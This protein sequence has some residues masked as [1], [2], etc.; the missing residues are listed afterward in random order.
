MKTA[1]V[2]VGAAMFLVDPCVR[3]AVARPVPVQDRQDSEGQGKPST[4]SNKDIAFLHKAAMGGL[5]EVKL[6]DAVAPKATRDEVRKFAQHMVEDHSKGNKEVLA[7]AQR[8]GLYD[9]PTKLDDDHQKQL[10]EVTKLVGDALD[11]KYVTLMVHDHQEDV[12]EFTRMSTD[13][14]D[15][16]VRALAAKTLPMLKEH[17]KTIQAIEAKLQSK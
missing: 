8:E 6:G 11:R 13:A 17:L 9:M 2:L 12:D 3:E 16:D 4:L 7:L 10:D 14:D 1:I 5:F 15:P